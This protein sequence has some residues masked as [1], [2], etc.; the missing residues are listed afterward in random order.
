MSADLSTNRLADSTRLTLPMDTLMK[1]LAHPLDLSL[2]HVPPSEAQ[3]T[4]ISSWDD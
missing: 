4:P 1:T 3:S 2:A